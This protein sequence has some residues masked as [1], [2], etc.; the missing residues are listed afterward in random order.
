MPP[1]PGSLPQQPSWAL[2][3][4]LKGKGELVVVR[5]E[6]LGREILVRAQELSRG[7]RLQ[8]LFCP[9]AGTVSKTH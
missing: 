6:E 4:K 9:M 1:L 8:G 2:I 5:K 7:P 3:E